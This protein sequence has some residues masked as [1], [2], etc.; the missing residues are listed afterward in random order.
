M[1]EKEQDDYYKDAKIRQMGLL[2]G[3]EYAC[4]L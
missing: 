1:I 3:R 2:K 4:V